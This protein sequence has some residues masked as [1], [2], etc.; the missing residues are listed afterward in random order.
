MREH[1]DIISAPSRISA[2]EAF[3]R[4]YEEMSAWL[5]TRNLGVDCLMWSKVCLS[6]PANQLALL[7]EHKLYTELLSAGAFSYVGQPLLNGSKL[8]VVFGV[9]LDNGITKEGTP[10]CMIVKNGKTKRIYQSIRLADAEAEGLTPDMQTELIFQRHIDKLAEMGLT[11]KD[12]CM[13]TWLYVSDIDRNYASVMKGRNSVFAREGLTRDTHYIASTG[14]EG[15]LAGV[16]PVIGIDFFSVESE[17]LAPLYL[18]APEYLNRTHEY[19][20]AFERGVKFVV[21][22]EEKIFI[23]GTASIDKHGACIFVGDVVRQTERLFLNISQLLS[24]AGRT[25]ED[26]A[27][28]V[29]Y[30]RDIADAYMLEDYLAVHFSGVPYVVV[31]ASVCR[32]AWLVEVECE[33]R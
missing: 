29:V 16:T 7:E 8:A 19:G 21:D 6:D 18:E 10:D 23:S 17:G 22:G 11:L 27:Y 31:E 3:D 14:I 9:D 25:L 20:V 15:Y 5:S 26:I 12:N 32:P 33:V 1:I 2:R 4:V 24:H 28:M 30:L 13:R